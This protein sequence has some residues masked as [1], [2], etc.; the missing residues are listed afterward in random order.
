MAWFRHIHGGATTSSTYTQDGRV[1]HAK[2]NGLSQCCRD[3]PPFCFRESQA[4]E[5]GHVWLIV[6]GIQGLPNW[7]E[8]GS[9]NTSP[10]AT[11]VP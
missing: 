1:M 8:E 11:I 5:L 4:H 7:A 2:V 3:Y 6:Y 10:I 9:A